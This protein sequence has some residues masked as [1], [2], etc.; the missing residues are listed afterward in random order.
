VSEKLIKLLKK[1]HFFTVYQLQRNRIVK[2]IF[3]NIATF[4]ENCNWLESGAEKSYSQKNR[5]FNDTTFM[6]L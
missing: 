6:A 2:K 5:F 3:L 4:F 1:N